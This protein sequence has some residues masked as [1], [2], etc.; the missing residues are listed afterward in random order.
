MNMNE[1]RVTSFRLTKATVDSL[2]ALKKQINTN[3]PIHLST[4]DIIEL[5]IRQASSDKIIKKV[6]EL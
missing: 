1:K 5:L 2:R 4:S 3:S 6:N